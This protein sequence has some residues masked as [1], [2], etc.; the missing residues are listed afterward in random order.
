MLGYIIVLIVGALIG[1]AIGRLTSNKEGETWQ[2]AVNPFDDQE[3]DVRDEYNDGL[4]VPITDV[5]EVAPEPAPV[6]EPAPIAEPD[7]IPAPEPTP[8]DWS[9]S[10]NIPGGDAGNDSG[11]VSP[12]VP[13]DEKPS[14]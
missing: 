14:Y 5:P 6:E 3:L 4:V 11:N 9:P 10:E 8:G 1:Y 12:V 7:F 13:E 2:D